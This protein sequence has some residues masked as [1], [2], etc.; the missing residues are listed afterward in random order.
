[1]TLS[2]TYGSTK[3]SDA[4][5]ARMT[6]FSETNGTRRA[7]VGDYKSSGWMANPDGWQGDEL[8]VDAK[9][10]SIKLSFLDDGVGGSAAGQSAGFW[11]KL[12]GGA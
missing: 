11:S 12:F 3:T 2:T 5:G 7:F 9:H 8:V 6:T 1:M 4:V 10:G